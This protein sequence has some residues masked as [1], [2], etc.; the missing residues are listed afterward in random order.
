MNNQLTTLFN[1][2]PADEQHAVWQ[3]LNSQPLRDFVLTGIRK[4]QQSMN[5]L[6]MPDT[7]ESEELMKFA[8]VY[9]GW[10][11]QVAFLQ[12]LITIETQYKQ[13]FMAADEES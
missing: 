9:R 3:A 4:A 10:R 7:F 2:L 11:D 8:Q 1:S 5:N 12:E 13:R 6:Q